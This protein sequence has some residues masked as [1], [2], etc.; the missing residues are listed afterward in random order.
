MYPKYH[1]FSVI[2]FRASLV[3]QMVK[4]LPAMQETHP[5]SISKLRR[6]TGGGNG[7]VQ[8]SSVA[9]SC[10]ALCDPLDCSMLGLPV[11]H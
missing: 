11:H 4:N 5:C 3:A 7:S 2:S 8:F 9:Q 6:S 1:L 10:P